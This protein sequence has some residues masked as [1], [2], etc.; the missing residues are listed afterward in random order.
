MYINVLDKVKFWIGLKSISF[1]KL[2]YFIDGMNEDQK[3][4]FI[5]SAI[6]L[7]S[8]DKI[9]LSLLPQFQILCFKYRQNI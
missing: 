9:F 1:N 5:S 8:N 4:R 7:I 3:N 2:L 6:G